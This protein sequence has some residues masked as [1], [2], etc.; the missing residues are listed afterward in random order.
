MEKIRKDIK[1]VQKVQ[2][3]MES[4]DLWA[5]IEEEY[6]EEE[7]EEMMKRV[8]NILDIMEQEMFNRL[9]AEEKQKKRR[10]F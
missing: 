9:K 5:Y 4:Y 7:T 6:G 8:D 3:I 10:R 2:N 1:Q